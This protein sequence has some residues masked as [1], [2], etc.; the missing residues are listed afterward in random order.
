MSE[1]EHANDSGGETLGAALA[2]QRRLTQAVSGGVGLAGLAA[3]LAELVGGP[4]AIWAA[5]IV[6]PVVSSPDVRPPNRPIPH[7]TR[8]WSDDAA[9]VHEEWLW[10]AAQP[11]GSESL[12]VVGIANSDEMASDE[13]RLALEETAVI[14]AL[15]VYRIQSVAAAEVRV[16]GALTDEIVDDH[17]RAR[18][19]AHAEALGFDLTTLRRVA[20]VT[21]DEIDPTVLLEKVLSVVGLA[22]ADVLVT[23]R[24][25]RVVMI[26]A[27]D[28]DQAMLFGL[29]R[30][31]LVGGRFAIGVSACHD[32]VR[33]Y[34]KA[35][36][37]AEVAAALG[38][39][40]QRDG[41]THYEDLGVYRLLATNGDT[42]ELDQFVK[43]WLGPVIEY[44]RTHHSEL[45]RSLS[46]Y[47]ERG[48]S[49]DQAAESLFIH[50]STLKYRLRRVASL[51]Q[52]DLTDPDARFNLQLATRVMA[53]IMALA[54]VSPP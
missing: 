1:S 23:A 54:A 36:H 4:A 31:A 19:L 11:A 38:T 42:T 25:D 21:S 39:A 48:G 45:V 16:W 30:K 41:V 35:A 17:N 27:D 33:E 29:L 6:A 40:M 14:A 7:T 3:V 53:T 52:V 34:P 5:C 24:G 47:L 50:R 44:D 26:V 32:V 49:L 28:F 20:T 22:S 13:H 12:V 37:E 8:G 18:V 10:R 2:I 43:R 15:E 46:E 51:A 9:F